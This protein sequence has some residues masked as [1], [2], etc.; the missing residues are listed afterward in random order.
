MNMRDQLRVGTAGIAGGSNRWPLPRPFTLI[1]LL[2]V[3]AI[4]AILAS[5]LLPALG[6]ARDTAQR[7][8]CTGNLKQIGIAFG[9]YV[10]DHEY[11]VTM[12]DAGSTADL[13][14]GLFY[15]GGEANAPTATIRPLYAYI[16]AVNLTR[17][18]TAKT[19]F[20]CPKDII[21]KNRNW[22]NATYYYWF[23]VSYD[24]NNAG[25]VYGYKTRLNSLGSGL[26]GRKSCTDASK[27]VMVQ[28]IGM[29]SNNSWHGPIMTNMVF[30]DGHVAMHYTP[31]PGTSWSTGGT[32]FTY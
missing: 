6:K 18:M 3:V 16:S 20:N 4:I 14:C 8:V 28:D 13:N 30:V 25:G 31:W 29:A 5:L 19:P 9:M 23:G 1:E 22:S 26:G 27:K 2:V 32:G 7:T 17:K 24:Y 11:F 21:G 10:D 12:G 15:G